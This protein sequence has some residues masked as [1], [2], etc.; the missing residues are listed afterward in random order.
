MEE[1]KD[2]NQTSKISAEEQKVILDEIKEQFTPAE[3]AHKEI[4]DGGFKWDEREDLFF[5]KYKH[6]EE[7]TKSVLST[8]EL[9]TLAIDG[10]CRVM[11]QLPT[12]RFYNFN[13]KT[14][15]NMLMN[16]L[17]EHYVLPNATNGG[18]MLLKHRLVNLYSRVFPYVPV[19]I[20]WKVNKNKGLDYAGPDMIVLHPRRF[21]PQP[22]KTSIEEMDYCFVDTEVSKEWLDGRDKKY[23]MNI[24]EVIRDADKGSG[25]PEE[26]RST[27]ERGKT[28]TGITIRHRFKSNGDW[29]VYCPVQDKL[30]MH[31]ADY[32]PGIPI[33]LK[34]QYPK[35]DQLA[36]LNDFDRGQGSQKSIDSLFRL[37]L[38]SIAASIDP[39]L[40]IDPEQVVL[41]SIV[42]QPKAKWFVKNGSMN[43]IEPANIS[44]QGFSD[45]QGTYGVLK[46]NLLSLGATTDTTVPKG[47]DPGFG[48][49]PEALKMQGER[50]G[51][52][53]AWDIFMME[54]FIE[55]VY[56]II[57]NMLAKK[58]VN[59]FAFRLLGNSMEKIKEQYPNEDVSGLLKQGKDGRYG[60]APQRIAGEYRYI[61]DQ[62]STLKKDDTG[63]KML[64][65][66]KLY[67]QYPEIKE[68][69]IASG[70][71][72][73]FAAAF[74]RVAIDSGVQDWEKI[75]ITEQNPEKTEGIGDSAATVEE[76]DEFIPQEEVSANQI[77]EETNEEQ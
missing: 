17:F 74:K 28:R 64:S 48:K 54:M 38:D 36:G 40:K 43:A 75:I 9:T 10:A 15:A 1:E 68:D 7:K 60:I 2:K 47:V 30:I 76:A 18:P 56:T 33:A 22:G 11:A 70:Q 13:G 14:A 42:R 50:Q 21:R 59:E 72:F 39:P 77:N 45:F 62:G 44:P 3:T 61:I 26:D 49:T 57:A 35:L 55:R 27:E 46:A 20:D 51:A 12:G 41:S 66:M 34:L 25:A 73:N 67:N 58:G 71:K 8:G 53:D 24:D 32:F 19:F 69:F 31:V 63:G 23:W 65:L 29:D 4:R 5:G 6:P 16:L 52:R 37:R